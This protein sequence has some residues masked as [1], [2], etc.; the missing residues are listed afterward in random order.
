M[1]RIILGFERNSFHREVGGAYPLWAEHCAASF[2][3]FITE[4]GTAIIVITI[5]HGQT[6]FLNLDLIE[7]L[8]E[9]I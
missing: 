6:I 8:V 4:T 9:I 7:Y 1:R 3:G 2:G 5:E